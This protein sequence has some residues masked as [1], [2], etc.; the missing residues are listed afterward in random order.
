M[1]SKR[2]EELNLCCVLSTFRKDSCLD[3]ASNLQAD[4]ACQSTLFTKELNF[5]ELSLQ[6]LTYVPH[7]TVAP[8]PKDAFFKTSP[9]L[10][11]YTKMHDINL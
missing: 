4:Y 1:H 2:S 8:L 10:L 7:T 11:K 6:M 3:Y 5:I 9:I